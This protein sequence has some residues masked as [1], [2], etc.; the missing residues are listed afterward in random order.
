MSRAFGFE[1]DFDIP[2]PDVSMPSSET[3]APFAPAPF[4][5]PTKKVVAAAGGVGVLALLFWKRKEI[6]VALETV[7]T[8]GG[9][10]AFRTILPARSQPFADA[11][12]D[13][14]QR[15]DVSPFV[16]WALLERE[17]RSGTMLAADGTGDHTARAGSWLKVPNVRIVDVLPAGW[18]APKGRDGLVPGPYAIPADGLGWGRGLMQVDWASNQDWLAANDWRNPAINIA[19]G[20]DI[21]IGKRGFLSATPAAGATV[22]GTDGK[23]YRDPRPI[24]GL[25]LVKASLAAYNRGEGGVL[26]AL[27][28]GRDPD[29]GTTGGDY[30]SDTFKDAQA[31][32]SKFAAKVPQTA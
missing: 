7:Y 8:A 20:A 18:A 11:L 26:V 16:L 30:A 27:A 1:P 21:F 3:I 25:A 13:V 5:T 2:L 6:I 15:K 32:A 31:M 12:L 24:S 22:R 9:K 17:T 28:M 4:W 10:I 29:G 19:K 14:S 23:A